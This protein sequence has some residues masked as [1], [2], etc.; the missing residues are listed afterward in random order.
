MARTPQLVTQRVEVT[1]YDQLTADRYEF[2]GLTQ[3]EPSLGAGTANSVLTLGA[4]NARIW[5]NTVTLNTVTATGN[6]TGGDIFTAGNISAAGN[7]TASNFSGTGNVSLGN[8]T[9]SNTTI[10][11]S[12][13]NG[14][15]TLTP[16]GTA[17]VAID[18]TTGLILPVGNTPQ[19][20]APASTGTVRFNTDSVRIE[21]YD[22][23]NWEDIAANVTNQTLNGDGNTTVFV[24]D[25]DSTTA[26][27]LVA[28]NGLV[29]L[30][31]TAY[32]VSGNS[33][34][35]TQ[36]PLITDVID[37]RFL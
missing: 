29:Q 6:L 28:I 15:I 21:V 5:S 35:F 2:L 16:T 11:T 13:A 14:N 8:L 12:L 34:T 31:T 24:L 23:S 22:G 32:S 20:P 18:T 7:V 36:A 26:A 19:R 33:I 27:T 3:A 10:S 17:V 30:P 4:A 1:P 9:I 37:L 25:R